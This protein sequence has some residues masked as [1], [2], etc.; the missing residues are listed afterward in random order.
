MPTNRLYSF[1]FPFDIQSTLEGWRDKLS[2]P[3]TGSYDSVVSRLSDRDRALED[4]LN[5]GVSQGYLGIGTVPNGGQALTAAYADVTGA[6]VSF[7]VPAG[8]RIKTTVYAT[9]S[10][11]GLAT[12]SF[13]RVLDEN[14]TVLIGDSAT[15]D[16]FGGTVA[17]YRF[18][19]IVLTTPT[20]GAHTYRLQAKVNN[21]NATLVS[22]DPA[23]NSG[24]TS[25]LS[26]E[27]IGPAA[28]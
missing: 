21:A 14:G 24:G 12:V 23:D 13:I 5:L 8:R 9:V 26:V 22:N 19:T 18:I 3:V 28:T 25:Y 16:A 10:N 4:H 1:R 6:S 7:S 11:I 15:L 2:S 27:D 20:T 17:A